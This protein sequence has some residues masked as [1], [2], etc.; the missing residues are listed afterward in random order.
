MYLFPTDYIIPNFEDWMWLLVLSWICSVWA[1]QLS[2]YALK[3]L[4]AFTVNLSFNLEP[5][6]GI[7]LAFIVFKESKELSLSFFAGLALIAAS[8]IIHVVLLIHE[9]RKIKVPENFNDSES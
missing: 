1:F 3:R 6:Y 5:I 4:T 2:A 7:L 9:E 8:L